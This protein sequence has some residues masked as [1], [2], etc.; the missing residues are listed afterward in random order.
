VKAS[1]LDLQS[2]DRNE[3]IIEICRH[4]NGTIYFSGNGGKKYHDESLFVKNG[5]TIKY[6]DF[7]PTEYP[8]VG[9]PFLP[10]MSII[11]VLLNCG[12]ENTISQLASK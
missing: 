7:K 2:E 9:T 4:L 5:I 1:D 11:D 12:I 8:Q 3:R 10:G 6:T